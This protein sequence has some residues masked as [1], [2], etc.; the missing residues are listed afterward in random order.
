MALK[1][2]IEGCCNNDRK[3]QKEIYELLAGKLYSSSLKYASSEED[4]QDILQDSFITI[5]KKVKQFNH[6]GS[7]EG[8]C[9]RIV[10][11]EALGRYRKNKLRTVSDER[12]LNIEAEV[13]EEDAEKIEL[14]YLLNLIHELPDRYRLVFS[15]YALDGYSH[16]EIAELMEITVGT[17]K[18]NLSRAR[19][20]LQEKVQNWRSNNKSSAI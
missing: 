4:A 9:R 3:S 19:N 11:N 1:E 15:L 6:K 20:L 16:K 10:V 13:D 5:F 18:S 12:L 2:L 8:W 14:N 7:F 17:S